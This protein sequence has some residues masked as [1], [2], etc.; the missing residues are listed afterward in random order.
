MNNKSILV[1]YLEFTEYYYINYFL[2]L[3]ASLYLPSIYYG[4]LYMKDKEFKIKHSLFLWNIFMSF[5]SFLGFYLIFVDQMEID[6][7]YYTKNFCDSSTNIENQK[8]SQLVCFIFC[9]TKILEWID[10]FFLVIKKRKIIFLHWF[11]HLITMLYCLHAI[12]YT[13]YFDYSGF[14]FTTVNLFVHAI[15]YFYYA[16]KVY[17]IYVPK[18]LVN[19]ITFIQLLQMFIGIYIIYLSTKCENSWNGNFNGILYGG[20]MYLVYIYLFSK[21]LINSLISKRNKLKI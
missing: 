13:A 2:L 1:E 9:Y 12:N 20:M 16:I 14:I 10:T 4:Q 17:K 8:N 7:V 6:S 11:H 21:V 15:M 3:L 5:S 19:S 18:I